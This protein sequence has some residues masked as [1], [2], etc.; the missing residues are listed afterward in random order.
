MKDF[1][2]TYFFVF[3]LIAL[4][5]LVLVIVS[6]IL[7]RI[8]FKERALELKEL[9][10]E[11]IKDA[12]I[13]GETLISLNEACYNLKKEEVENLIVKYVETLK[14]DNPE[15]KRKKPNK[16]VYSKEM[17]EIKTE[18]QQKNNNTQKIKNRNVYYLEEP[19]PEPEYITGWATERSNS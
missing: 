1:V 3:A 4:I 8:K 16:K 6:G 14:N 7:E 17:K 12:K 11:L 13:I 2:I 5:F 10:K 18:E 19:E 15:V 9:Q